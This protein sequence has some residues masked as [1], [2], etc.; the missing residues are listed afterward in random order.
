MNHGRRGIAGYTFAHCPTLHGSAEMMQQEFLPAGL[1]KADG[2]GGHGAFLIN[3]VCVF[4]YP[5]Y[6]DGDMGF[7]RICFPCG[8]CQ[9]KRPWDIMLVL[10]PSR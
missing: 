10:R 5:P 1:E 7:G 9:Q 2:N 3:C 8:I 4:Q 6:T